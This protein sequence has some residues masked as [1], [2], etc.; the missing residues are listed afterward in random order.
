[1]LKSWCTRLIFFLNISAILILVLITLPSVIFVSI[2]MLI[3]K[4]T[5]PNK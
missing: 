5:V 1:M 3:K 2:H 4:E